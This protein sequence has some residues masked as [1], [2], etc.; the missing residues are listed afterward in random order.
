MRTEKTNFDDEDDNNVDYNV[1]TCKILSSNIKNLA[2]EDISILD[3]ARYPTKLLIAGLI[4][5][6]AKKRNSGV[7]IYIR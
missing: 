3:Y 5:I 4:L 6:S 2:F 7:C 1:G